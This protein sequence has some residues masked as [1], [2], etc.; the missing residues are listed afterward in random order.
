M[1]NLYRSLFLTAKISLAYLFFAPPT[2]A[3]ISPDGSMPTQVSNSPNLS[4][5]W[6]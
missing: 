2:T 4:K 1:N 3:Q 6:V 5:N